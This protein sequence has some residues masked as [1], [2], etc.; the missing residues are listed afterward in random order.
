MR[1]CAWR[2]KWHARFFTIARDVARS[3]LAREREHEFARESESNKQLKQNW[4]HRATL[5]YARRGKSRADEKGRVSLYLTLLVVRFPIYARLMLRIE[6][7]MQQLYT[8]DSEEEWCHERVLF[9]RLLDKRERALIRGGGT[10][11]VCWKQGD[12]WDPLGGVYQQPNKRRS[13]QGFS[14]NLVTRLKVFVISRFG[15]ENVSSTISI[16]RHIGNQCQDHLAF[17]INAWNQSRRSISTPPSS[18]SCCLQATVQC[19]Q[20]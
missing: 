7:K 2:N 15:S 10:Y 14:A 5:H 1:V 4:Q 16:V 3:R 12:L 11:S 8:L 9:P 19:H 13:Y 18:L 20:Y 17:W 6:K